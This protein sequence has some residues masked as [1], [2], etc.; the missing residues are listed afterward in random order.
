MSHH[1]FVNSNNRSG[2]HWSQP[3]TVNWDPLTSA[4]STNKN[5]VPNP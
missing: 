4:N 2:G 5:P 3:V 1:F